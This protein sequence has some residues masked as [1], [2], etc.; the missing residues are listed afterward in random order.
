MYEF[1]K[2]ELNGELKNPDIINFIFAG[3]PSLV[4]ASFTFKDEHYF[5][6]DEMFL[7]F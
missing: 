4:Q 5:F 1:N 7:I 6:K 3:L 2:T